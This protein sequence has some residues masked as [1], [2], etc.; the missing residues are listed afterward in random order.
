M[1]QYRNLQG[2]LGRA[3]VCVPAKTSSSSFW[4]MMYSSLTSQK[5]PSSRKHRCFVHSIKSKKSLSKHCSAWPNVKGLTLLQ[6]SH[7]DAFSMKIMRDPLRRVISA[8]KSKF[9]CNE[10]IGQGS[11]VDKYDRLR[12]VR[13]FFTKRSREYKAK[14]TAFQPL[15]IHMLR[16]LSSRKS[17]NEHIRLQ[18]LLCGN[19]YHHVVRLEDILENSF[20]PLLKHLGSVVIGY[21]HHHASETM[22]QHNSSTGRTVDAHGKAQKEEYTLVV[23]MIYQVYAE[24]YRILGYPQNIDTDTDYLTETFSELK[25]V[26]FN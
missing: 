20:E 3:H 10:C 5:F 1:L 8:W 17:W 12:F 25:Q 22:P 7:S 16:S 24:D 21:P 2:R 11:T 9:R 13:K 23:K 14:C 15:I 18:T 26:C 19:E 4:G 6:R